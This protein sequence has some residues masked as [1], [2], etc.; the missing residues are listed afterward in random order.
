MWRRRPARGLIKAPK[1]RTLRE[2]VEPT[3]YAVPNPSIIRTHNVCLSIPA[4]SRFHGDSSSKEQLPVRLARSILLLHMFL[5]KWSSVP[6]LFLAGV[7]AGHPNES[8]LPSEQIIYHFID[9]AHASCTT[10]WHIVCIVYIC[11]AP[12]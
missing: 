9:K 12:A 4:A 10:S 3:S 7:R 2:A 6:I 11:G 1:R 5:S 8:R